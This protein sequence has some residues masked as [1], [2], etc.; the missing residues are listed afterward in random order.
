M[1]TTTLSTKVS[2]LSIG[3]TNSSPKSRGAPSSGGTGRWAREPITLLKRDV[4]SRFVLFDGK[5]EVGI[6]IY[7]LHH[8]VF[9]LR[10]YKAYIEPHFVKVS[11]LGPGRDPDFDALVQARWHEYLAEGYLKTTGSKMSA[12]GVK[13]DETRVNT[14]VQLYLA[15]RRLARAQ[16]E[17]KI[18]DRLLQNELD[19]LL[20]QRMLS[21]LSVHS[22]H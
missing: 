11:D 4:Y 9:N 19:P 22:Y 8:R 3:T 7:S 6:Q 13:L 18:Y 16:L 12:S 21:H 15:Y 20:R 5:K 2:E 1:S 14:P 17:T 10:I